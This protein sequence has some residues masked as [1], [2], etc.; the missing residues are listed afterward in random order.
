MNHSQR[1]FTRTHRSLHWLCLL[2]LQFGMEFIWLIILVIIIEYLGFVQWALLTNVT[3]FLYK[4]SYKFKAFNN[5]PVFSFLTWFSGH[6]VLN[7][8]GTGIVI[9]DWNKT[10][11]FY[12]SL[13]WFGS[14]LLITTHLFFSITKWGQR[15][16]KK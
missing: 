16:Q 10:I 1:S 4:A 8:I 3:K 12:N 6:C 15:S 7:Y 5:N 14:I 13:Y 2:F 11:T 9:L